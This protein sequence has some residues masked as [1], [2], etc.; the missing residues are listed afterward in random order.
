MD[1]QPRPTGDR[2]EAP[3]GGTPS[4]ALS[5]VMVAGEASGDWAGA[6]LAGVLGRARPDI[7]LRGVGGQRMAAAGVELLADSSTWGAIGV[8]EAIPKIPRVWR[9]L[10][11]LRGLLA[12]APPSALV[13]IDFGAGNIGL[14][15]WAQG[16]HIPTLYYLPPGSWRQRPR[17]V[18][19]RDLVDVIATPFS[20]S[21]D[22]LAGGRARVEWV[23]H[24]VV[25]AA[26]PELTRDEAWS[27]YD[28]DRNRPVVALAPGSRQQE[29]HYL[30]PTL[31]EAA[32]RLGSRFPGVQFL[33]P[34]APSLA[35]EEVT[36]LFGRAGV[37]VV[38]LAGMDYGAL[39]LAEAAAVCS[40]TATLEFTCLGVPMVVVYRA[41]RATTLQYR[42]VRGLIGGQRFAAMPNII[43][44]RQVVRE[45][46][47]SAASPEAIVQELS[48]LLSED[49]HRE[50]ARSD[51]ALVKAT[52]G[53]PSASQR[54]AQLLLEL[55]DRGG[56][57][58]GPRG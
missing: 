12:S 4:Q 53:P 49:G 10:R 43:A 21:R 29:M 34:I 27:R 22:L 51:L 11:M 8:F 48:G 1:H 56:Q 5:V 15:R 24:P 44:C 14:A 28:L 39:Q 52:L 26:R 31:A 9:A 37:T 30:L 58:R 2:G 46:L 47:G 41:S 20:W 32:A 54:T 25:E 23:G 42:L 13:L 18:E 40:G 3:S 17:S 57:G 45:L 16:R 50:R 19:V 7:V 55:I 33:V 6:R 35:Q 36:G 38:P